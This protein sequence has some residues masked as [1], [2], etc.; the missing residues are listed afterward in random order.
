MK[1]KQKRTKIDG[2]QSSKGSGEGIEEKAI[3][4]KRGRK[5]IG[6]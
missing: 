1:K 3:Q 2:K 6:L 5:E 4:K